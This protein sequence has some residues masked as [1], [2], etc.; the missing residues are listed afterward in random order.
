M[1]WVC[2]RFQWENGVVSLFA[3]SGFRNY[4]YTKKSFCLVAQHQSVY[5]S[6]NLHPVLRDYSDLNH[7]R[8]FM[9]SGYHDYEPLMQETSNLNCD[10][11][12]FGD[13][14]FKVVSEPYRQL[15][16]IINF[17]RI[18]KAMKQDY[19]LMARRKRTDYESVCISFEIS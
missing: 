11:C 4:L 13:G 1:F 12:M 15:Y 9:Q 7:T 18:G 10:Y 17:I 16:T 3:S 19:T 14:V 5:K 6:E 2:V 8:E